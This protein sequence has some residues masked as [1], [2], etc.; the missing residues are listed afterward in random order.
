MRTFAS[1]NGYISLDRGSQQFQVNRFPYSAIPPS[2]IAPFF[3]DT[4]LYG[5]KNP[6]Q[7]I[8][9]QIDG[10]KV[11]WEYYIGR[12][13]QL[14]ADKARLSQSIYH[15]TMEYDSAVPNVFVYTYYNLGNTAQQDPGVN[16]ASAAVGMQGGEYHY[17]PDINR[18]TTLNGN[19]C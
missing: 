6:R 10:T 16:G 4:A 19:T 14:D 8:Y 3:D 5:R 11:T 17:Y 18:D 12:S 1:S 15:Y 9:Y 13:A 2:S 7:G